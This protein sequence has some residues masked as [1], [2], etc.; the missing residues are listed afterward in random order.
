M[1]DIYTLCT[2]C[3]THRSEDRQ[4]EKHLALPQYLGV[5]SEYL[6]DPEFRYGSRRPWR[7]YSWDEL[8]SAH[9]VRGALGDSREYVKQPEWL[10]S[11]RATRHSE[12]RAP[13]TLSLTQA[14][15]Q[16]RGWR[17][18]K[19]LRARRQAAA[20]FHGPAPVAREFTLTVFVLVAANA[21]PRAHVEQ[22]IAR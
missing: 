14:G 12:S 1:I 9:T 7:N 17:E 15:K 8:S 6:C 20:P 3:S 16:D 2:F 21:D 5:L 4:R 18:K 13:Q 10:L 19:L 22:S 11:A